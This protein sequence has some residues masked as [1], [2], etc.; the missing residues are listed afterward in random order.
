V[1]GRLRYRSM[2]PRDVRGCVDLI[3]SHPVI[4]P[5]YGRTIEHLHGVWLSLLE[6]EASAA[7]VFYAD[8]SPNAPICFFGNTVAVNDDF[9]R[10]MKTPPHFWIGPELTRRI[11]SGASPVLNSKEFRE[12]NSHGGLNMVCW[13]NCPRSGYE[14]NT[15]LHRYIMSVF[16]QLHQGYLWKE[17]IANQPESPDRLGFFLST[18]ALLWDP[19]ARGYT[20]T[21]SEGPHE[22]VHK[23]HIFGLTREVELDR[24]HDWLGRWVGV[25]FDY[26]APILGLSRNEQRLLV[27]A[28][29][30]ATD[31]QLAGVLGTSIPSV[32]KMWV[33][34]YR[35][36]EDRLPELIPDP[37]RL[38]ISTNVRGREKRRRL[39]SYLRE[40]SEELR[41][42]SRKHLAN[43]NS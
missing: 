43:A 31:E 42:Y 30:G 34:V 33:S 8:D 25:L 21:L 2:E 28:L 13:E 15:E 36:V 26:H 4:G 19:L 3:A 38:E 17:V 16:L 18:G 12:A 27:R 37:Q 24:R 35:R 5:R 11:A 7:T 1:S 10:D 6:R 14:A 23:P 9:V 39:L 22:I 20:S 40:H 29:Q 41:P 32:K